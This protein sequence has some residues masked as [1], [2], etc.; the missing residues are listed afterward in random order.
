MKKNL[1]CK[2]VRYS[3][4]ITV[5][6]LFMVSLMTVEV[7]AQ[8][9]DKAQQVEYKVGIL[10]CPDHP[11]VEWNDANM[12]RMKYL[13]FNTMQLNIAWSWRPNDEALN[14]EDVV[15]LPK[16]FE[17]AIDRDLSK[18]LRTPEK[19][20]AR[21]EKLKQ[22][23]AICKKY[24]FRAIF[25]FGAPFVG[26]PPQQQEPLPQCIMNTA[27]INRYIKLIKDFGKKFPGVDDLLLYT[28]DQDAWLC[29]E[30]GPCPRCHGVP[31]A[32]RVSMFVNTL[33]RTWKKINPKGTL[34]WEPWELSAGEVYKTMDLLD[35]SCV[36]MSI[37]SSVAEVMIA[38]PA[39]RWFKNVLY[40]AK[41]RHIP[42]IG[43]VWTGGPT[44]E[45]EPYTH[46]QCPLATLQ[47]LRAINNAGKLTGIK[48]YYGNVPDEE[49][50]NLRMTGIFFHNPDITDNAA[51]AELA[52]PYMQAAEDVAKYWKLSS[53]AVEFYPWDVS[54]FAREVGR[55]NPVHSMTA[56]VLKGGCIWQT[57][58]W[59]STRKTAFMRTDETN[60]PNFWMREDL[61]LRFEQAATKMQQAIATAK[62]VRDKVPEKFKG[63]F[64]KSI[65]ELIGFK[66][67]TL[68]YAYH[69]RETN[70][71]NL[72]RS[73]IKMGLPIKNRTENIAELR[74]ILLKD[75]ENQENSEPIA[76]AIKLLDK[77]LNKFLKTY[78]LPSQPAN[79]KGDIFSAKNKKLWDLTSQ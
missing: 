9:K 64:D 19:I 78:F 4:F 30:F 29:S 55:S 3:I 53:E 37:H 60:Q 33:A 46:I 72:I 49:D 2:N 77:N 25:H 68:A 42:V 43:E 8:Q 13:G 41:E 69:L 35:S 71:A 23:I 76:M 75:Q 44:E 36:G 1:I 12:K 39:D 47:Q 32:D 21:S 63:V 70:L 62:V 31:V 56:A 50:P 40:K 10:G 14:L 16:Q 6:S 57:P 17:L 58:S 48:E 27:T 24:G 59:Q 65:E 15:A 79:F 67:R 38:N 74:A 26:Y 11:N 5:F 7:K 18:T 28:Y 51:L 66:V 61:Q 22:R 73:S 54:W 45:M 20:E 34:W 52:E